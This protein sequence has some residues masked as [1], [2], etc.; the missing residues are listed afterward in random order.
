MSKDNNA[1]AIL[2]FTTGAGLA[3][4]TGT[5]VWLYGIYIGSVASTV[6]I[7]SGLAGTVSQISVVASMDF[8]TPLQLAAGTAT[9]T[10]SGGSAAVAYRAR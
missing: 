4:G 10:S 8:A 7:K 5:S 3:L 9:M 2:A 6:T 1:A